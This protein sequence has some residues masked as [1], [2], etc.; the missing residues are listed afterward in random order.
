M[1]RPI[2]TSRSGSGFLLTSLLDEPGH[3]IGQ[4]RTLAL[5]ESEAFTVDAQAFASLG[6][7]GIIEPETFDEAAITREAR[8][9]NDKIEKRA[10][11]GAPAS[12]SNHYHVGIPGD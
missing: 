11:F 5:P 8:V 10:F 12:Q 6:R 2:T 7:L 9:S 3:G 4:L 1:M